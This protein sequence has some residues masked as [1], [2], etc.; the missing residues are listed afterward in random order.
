MKSLLKISREI[1]AIAQTGLAYCKDPYD[2]DRYARLEAI[3]TEMVREGHNLEDFQW[4][5]ETGYPTPKVDVRGF[6]FRD[7][8]LLMV[9]EASSGKWSVP[10]GWADVN[11]T[12][13]ENVEKECLEETGHTVRAET[14]LSVLDRD[15]AGYPRFPEAIYKIHFLCEYL[16]GEPRPSFE[17]PEVAFF[18]LDALPEID[19]CRIQMRDIERAQT[20]M[21]HPANQTWFQRSS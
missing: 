21:K 14:I 12:P 7:D 5:A 3:A 8:S 11:L 4:P 17:T 6:V 19:T 20:C 10:G 1:R 9:R 15:R 16:S 13:A 2:R 18:P